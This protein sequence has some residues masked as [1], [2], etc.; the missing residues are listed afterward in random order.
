[1]R[2]STLLLLSPLALGCVSS[3]ETPNDQAM[4]RD[5]TGVVQDFAGVVQDFAMTPGDLATGYPAGP[6]GA[7]VGDVIFP[8]DWMG[9]NDEAADALATT[10]TYGPYSMNDLRVSGKTYG[11]VHVASFG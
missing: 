2:R 5:L 11:I 8:L 6:Y 10:K 1:M 9:Y 3:T 7:N 4:A